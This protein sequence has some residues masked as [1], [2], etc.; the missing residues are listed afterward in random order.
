MVFE[1]II[2]SNTGTSTFTATPLQEKALDYD[3]PYP[4]QKF[5]DE[6]IREADNSIIRLAEGERVRAMKD[7]NTVSMPATYQALAQ[8]ANLPTALQRAPRS[9]DPLAAPRRPP[10]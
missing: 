2:R 7:P 3:I 8:Q 4:R 6:I 10:V 9:L 1:V 5:M